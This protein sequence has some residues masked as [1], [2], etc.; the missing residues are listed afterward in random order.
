[1]WSALFGDD[2]QPCGSFCFAFPK[3]TEDILPH[4]FND[5]VRVL[6]Q[7]SSELFDWWLFFFIICCRKGITKN[8]EMRFSIA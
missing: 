2:A 7:Y 4:L 6:A 3:I 1:V 5:D 8:L